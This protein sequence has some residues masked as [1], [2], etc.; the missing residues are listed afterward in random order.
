MISY[1]IKLTKA[2]TGG[3]SKKLLVKILQYS[4]ETLVQEP[5]CV[6]VGGLQLY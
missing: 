1:F 5:L 6:E 3:V 4:Q 2:A